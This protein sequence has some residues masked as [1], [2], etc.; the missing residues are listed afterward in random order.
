MTT[1]HTYPSPLVQNQPG[2]LTYSNPA[3]LGR[4]YDSYVLKNVLGS[5]V[6]DPFVYSPTLPLISSTFASSV[7]LGN[8]SGL[9]FD[10]SGNLYVVAYGDP[11]IYSITP[12]GV[13]SPFTTI[14]TGTYAN[15]FSVFDT[16][17]NLYVTNDTDGTI[18]IITP[19]G[20][21]NIFNNSITD[22]VGMRSITVFYMFHHPLLTLF[23][24]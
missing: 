7:S 11:I 3:V 8:L 5:I 12:T 4:A 1:I 21:S 14:T 15:R 6:S 9:A 20:V 13:M 19:S 17:G 16:S 2:I 22:P 24:K 18:Y 10:T 23:I